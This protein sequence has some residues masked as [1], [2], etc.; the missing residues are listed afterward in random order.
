MFKME[1]GR[2]MN[3]VFQ[4]N[5]SVLVAK[6]HEERKVCEKI[7]QMKAE[8]DSVK[9]ELEECAYSKQKEDLLTTNDGQIYLDEHEFNLITRLKKLKSE[10]RSSWEHLQDI[11]SDFL[12]CSNMVK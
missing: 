5:K 9:Q 10:Y 1:V 6:K 12:Y 8:M 7:N 3:M 11:R 4:E 2:D